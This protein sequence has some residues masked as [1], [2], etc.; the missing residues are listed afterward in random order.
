VIDNDDRK[1]YVRKYYTHNV[2]S[3]WRSEYELYF[4][5]RR[6]RIRFLLFNAWWNFA[7]RSRLERVQD[8]F[9]DLTHK[10]MRDEKTVFDD[11]LERPGVRNDLK[12]YD[13]DHKNN[14]IIGRVERIT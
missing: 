12:H 7:W 14:T 6:D 1:V 9:F 3:G 4:Q 13:L 2:D 8:W 5:P 11:F 10:S